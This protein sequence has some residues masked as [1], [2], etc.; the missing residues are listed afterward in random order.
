MRKLTHQIQLDPDEP[1]PSSLPASKCVHCGEVVTKVQEIAL[2]RYAWELLKPIDCNPDT[3]GFERHMPTRFQLMPPKP[4]VRSTSH[5]EDSGMHLTDAETLS[6]IAVSPSA[7]ESTLPF[8]NGQ[9]ASPLSIPSPLDHSRSV[10]DILSSPR[11][12]GLRLALS[13]PLIDQFPSEGVTFLA[14]SKHDDSKGLPL[15]A[16]PPPLLKPVLD[17]PLSPVPFSPDTVGPPMDF[18]AQSSATPVTESVQF[19]KI[20]LASSQAPLEKRRSKWRSKLTI[21]RKDSTAAS[22]DSSSLSSSTLESQKLE[23]IGLD[24]L[25]KASKAA[26]RAKVSKNVNV[27]LSQNST[28]ALFWTQPLVHIYDIG[29]SPPHMIRSVATQSS[30]VLAA[31]TKVYLAYVVG[32]R[33]QKLSVSHHI[34]T[35]KLVS[36][37]D[38][39]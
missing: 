13:S 18:P 12:P 3:I 4:S 36:C 21:S 6:P 35:I 39:H 23:E 32:T 16:R 25:L 27:A 11:S 10:P 8:Q 15:K 37:A 19:P 26:A 22:R 14:K 29:P 30:C 7:T 24:G 2:A 9:S 31:V 28:L 34:T 20:D 33:D 38:E 17:A 5:S 1:T